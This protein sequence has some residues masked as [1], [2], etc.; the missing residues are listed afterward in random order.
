M[1]PHT[2]HLK[3]LALYGVSSCSRLGKRGNS[4]Q[5]Q[6]TARRLLPS[7]L[8]SAAAPFPRVRHPVVL[9]MTVFDLQ[10]SL[11]HRDPSQR[12]PLP[13]KPPAASLNQKRRQ[14]R[15]RQTHEERQS[16]FV[17]V[18]ET[19]RQ[20]GGGLWGGGAEAVKEK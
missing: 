16:V 14:P 18:A 5:T 4:R 9:I 12:E 11:S 19:R 7:G 3:T 15:T 2:Q 10:L 17:G 8:L 13:T 6:Q 1:S 20:R